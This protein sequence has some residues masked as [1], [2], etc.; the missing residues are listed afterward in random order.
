MILNDIAEAVGMHESTIS[1][2]TT[3]SL[4]Q[5]PMGTLELKAF[6]SVGIK[7]EASAEPTSAKSIRYLI[8]KLIN[9][10]DPNGPISDDTIVETLAKDGISVAR[11]TVAKYRKLE[12]IPSSFSRKRHNILSGSMG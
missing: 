9:Q 12:G 4:I 1:R 3:G 5:T 6:F 11:R 7:Q 10:E 8:K 2:V